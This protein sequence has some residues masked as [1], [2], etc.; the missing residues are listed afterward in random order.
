MVE[1]IG[2][3]MMAQAFAYYFLRVLCAPNVEGNRQVGPGSNKAALDACRLRGVHRHCRLGK[4][5]KTFYGFCPLLRRQSCQDL[6]YPLAVE[7]R[8]G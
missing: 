4:Q 5:G 1:A 8:Y 2:D 6:A 7:Y 3:D